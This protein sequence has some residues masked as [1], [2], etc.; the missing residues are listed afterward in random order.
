MTAEYKIGLAPVELEAADPKAKPVLEKAKAQVG[1]IPNMYKG[2]VNFPELLDTYLDGYNRFRK[3][4]TFN[5]VEQELILLTVSRVHGCNY[6]TAA[7]SMIADRS[8]MPADVLQAI[9]SGGP[10]RDAKLS[11]LR[12]FVQKMVE[13]R[14]LPSRADAAAFLAAGYSDRH[15]LE[16]ILAISVKVIS[17]FSNHL[18]HTEID[19]PFA[20]YAI[21]S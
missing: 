21:K 15:M 13:S 16:V 12:A 14:G 7:H 8:K 17:N 11:A 4:S 1:F 2:M 6:C 18:F 19:Q 3:A 10:I 5:P 9:R 20:G